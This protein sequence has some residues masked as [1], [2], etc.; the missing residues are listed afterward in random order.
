MKINETVLTKDNVNIY[1]P[2]TEF[3]HIFNN[4]Y[5]LKNELLQ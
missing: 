1:R 5:G 4:K 2:L 3:K